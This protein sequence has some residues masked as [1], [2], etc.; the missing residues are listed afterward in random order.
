MHTWP[1]APNARVG[2]LYTLPGVI[3]RL[4]PP[5]I[6]QGVTCASNKPLSATHRIPL[7]CDVL[8]WDKHQ[9]VISISQANNRSRALPALFIHCTTALTWPAAAA[10]CALLGLLLSRLGC[11]G[12][13]SLGEPAPAAAAEGHLPSELGLSPM[14]CWL[15]KLG[16]LHKSTTNSIEGL[17]QDQHTSTRTHCRSEASTISIQV[18]QLMDEGDARAAAGAT[19]QQAQAAHHCFACSPNTHWLPLTPLGWGCLRC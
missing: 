6:E 5:P 13:T 12:D 17:R 11:S 19:P 14:P 9:H 4:G 15:A 16:L 3:A 7:S 1:D 18:Q 2:V 8:C 10:S